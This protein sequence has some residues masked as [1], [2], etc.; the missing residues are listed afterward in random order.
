VTIS[1]SQLRI[2]PGGDNNPATI[3]ARIGAINS[4]LTAQGGSAAKIKGVMLTIADD[5]PNYVSRV[6][7]NN[8]AA[9]VYSTIKSA[10]TGGLLHTYYNEPTLSAVRNADWLVPLN[11]N[12]AS[13]HTAEQQA[14]AR[15]GF[16]A[17]ID[18]SWLSGWGTR[19]TN[20]SKGALQ[21]FRDFALASKTGTIAQAFTHYVRL[22]WEFNGKWFGWGDANNNAKWAEAYRAVVTAMRAVNPNLKFV[23]CPASGP[24]DL[25]PVIAKAELMASWPGSEY[26]DV[27]GLDIY[28]RPDG[29]SGPRLITAASFAE[30]Y[31]PKLDTILSIA[32][33]KDKPICFPEW[34]LG[35]DDMQGLEW[36]RQM[37]IWMKALPAT[38]AG[39]LLYHQWFSPTT[40]KSKD[41]QGLP[42]IAG[43]T[44]I[45]TPENGSTNPKHKLIET[46]AW[47]AKFFG[48]LVDPATTPAFANSD[49]PAGGTPT[50]TLT[51]SSTSLP[52]GTARES[53]DAKLT[54]SG[55]TGVG[56]S[57]SI[58][59]GSLPAGLSMDSA[60]N[61]TGV[62]TTQ[63]TSVLTFRVSEGAVQATKSL[64][65]TINGE[66][67]VT[68]ASLADGEAGE[69]YS[70][71]LTAT[72]GSGEY[73]WN[74]LSGSLPP[75]LVL[76]ETPDPA[77]SSTTISGTP[78][79]AGQYTFVIK[80]RDLV[81]VSTGD[82]PALDQLSSKSFSMK[83]VSTTDIT[84]AQ[85]GFSDENLI[86]ERA[87]Y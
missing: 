24:I 62:P 30:S 3:K 21:C 31:K 29:G 7:A 60:G 67:V 54:A 49:L 58:S 15:L 71:V 13:V 23:W 2:N 42:R 81:P 18:D 64:G 69:A 77:G 80:A 76:D 36:L 82:G 25:N 56:R 72:G 55:G 4:K 9:P 5:S 1:K 78:T 84:L 28:H 22:G 10:W 27:I 61:I 75:G 57:W 70:A 41:G 39:S 51:V 12:V 6:I 44:D 26:V 86:L 68:T 85:A 8:V 32:L 48:G 87:V 19:P 11:F 17:I 59:A 37:A 34:A 74:V 50:P 43:Y 52:T 79:V 38:G 45:I 14:A 47:Y 20:G 83:I 53:Y 46:Q 73:E 35:G 16:Q 63:G 33:D 65:I 66:I 40:G